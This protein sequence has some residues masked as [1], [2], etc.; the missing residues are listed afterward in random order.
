MQMEKFAKQAL[1]EGVNHQEELIVTTES[2]I[3]KQ[4][5]QHYNKNNVFEPPER[6]L[7]VVQETLREFFSALQQQKDLEPSWKKSIYKIIQQLDEPIPDYF[8][9]FQFVEMLENAP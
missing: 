3:F 5:N 1:A 7:F 6:L 4:L 8:R 2:E 9:D